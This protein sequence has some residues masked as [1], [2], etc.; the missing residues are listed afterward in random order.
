VTSVISY[1]QSG[2]NGGTW[3]GTA[4]IISTSITGGSPGLSLGYADGNTDSGTPAGPNQI[5]VKYTLAGDANLDGLVNFNDLVA[6]VQNF[7]KSGTDWAEGNFLYGSSTSFNDLVAVVQNF[8]KIL[9]PPSGSDIELGTTIIP[10]SRG[11]EIQPD[12]VRVPEPG[13]IGLA[14]LA[15][16]GLLSRR[17]RRNSM[18]GKSD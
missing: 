8:N 16:G 11:I 5:V 17:R 13:G 2:Y 15:C 12:A 9:P 4:G 1:L 18:R 3:T 14:T 10:L 7:N 6:V